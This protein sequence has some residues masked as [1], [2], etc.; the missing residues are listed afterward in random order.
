MYWLNSEV[1]IEEG[2]IVH[3]WGQGI[4]RSNNKIVLSN[5]GP[6]YLDMG[7]GNY[8]GVNYGN[9]VSWLDLYNT[10]IPFDKN[11]LGAEVCL[12]SEINN[13]YT[14]HMKIWIRSSSFAEKTWNLNKNPAKPWFFGRITAHE[15]LM[16]RRG[17]PTA[18][19]TCQQC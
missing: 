3:W 15:R 19:A 1:K 18:P 4:P 6:F 17:I 16:N 9:Y 11:I 10:Q 7:V 2:D 8:Y 5:Y 14:H 12:W 13:R